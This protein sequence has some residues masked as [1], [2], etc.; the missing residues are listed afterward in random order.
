[1]TAFG[2]VTIWTLVSKAGVKYQTLAFEP[3]PKPDFSK[4][5]D[6]RDGPGQ[7]EPELIFADEL[8]F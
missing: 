5:V 4:P 3:A 8:P 2:S 7:S 1:M 6:V